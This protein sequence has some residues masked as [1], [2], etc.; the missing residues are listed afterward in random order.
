MKYI[1][2]LIMIFAITSSFSQ[3][4]SLGDNLYAELNKIAEPNYFETIISTG[5]IEDEG[6]FYIGDKPI[7]GNCNVVFM[8]LK[9]STLF[10]VYVKTPEADFMFDSQGDSILD[11]SPGYFMYPMWVIKENTKISPDDMKIIEVLNYIYEKTL[12]LDDFD[13][14]VNPYENFVKYRT[15]TTLANRHIAYL[16]ENSLIVSTEI[17]Q[18][19]SPELRKI[20]LDLNRSMASECLSLFGAIP[21]IVYIYL[22][23][24]LIGYDMIDEAIEN[25]EVA[26]QLYPDCIP[27][28]V[29]SCVLEK[30]PVKKS[31][32][33]KELRKK[34]PNHWLVKEL[35]K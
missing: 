24:D 17:S 31:E 28:K 14:R 2:L 25:F 16:F 3:E 11:V 4:I 33:S 15:D 30:D 29:Y 32:K 9:D 6:S 7:F 1:L 22:G 26:L 20:S 19:D 18:N 27:C 10:G 21:V 35:I 13:E 8:A 23:E 12:Q 34:H 5:W